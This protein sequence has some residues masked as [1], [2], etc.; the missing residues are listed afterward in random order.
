MLLSPF[1]PGN[2]HTV[3]IW[4]GQNFEMCLFSSF[5]IGRSPEHTWERAQQIFLYVLLLLLHPSRTGPCSRSGFNQLFHF[6]NNSRL[7]RAWCSPRELSL[8]LLRAVCFSQEGEGTVPSQAARSQ[9]HVVSF[10]PSRRKQKWQSFWHP[11]VQL[12]PWNSCDP[13]GLP[14]CPWNVTQALRTN[15]TGLVHS[16]MNP[17]PV[18]DQEVDKLISNEWQW[19]DIGGEF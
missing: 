18:Q 9:H 13:G 15:C 12:F 7:H 2:A 8:S 14:L 4:C 16:N 3:R 17:S 1:N 5:L 10:L 19:S 6:R 11:V